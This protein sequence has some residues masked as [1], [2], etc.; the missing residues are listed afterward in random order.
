MLFQELLAQH[1]V[2]FIQWRNNCLLQIILSSG[3]LINIC[4]NIFTGDVLKIVYD[5]YLIG[6]L[7]SEYVADGEYFL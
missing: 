3:M 7:L 1:K 2:V 6:K 5:K 4:V